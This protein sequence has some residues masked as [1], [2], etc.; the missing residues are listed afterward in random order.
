MQRQLTFE[1]LKDSDIELRILP[2]EKLFEIADADLLIALGREEDSRF[3]RK[4]P[5]IGPRGLGEYF[6]MWANTP[7]GGLIVVGQED[8]GELLGLLSLSTKQIN[9]IE[10]TPSDYCPDAVYRHKKILFKKE[11]GKDDFL[12]LFYVEY[13]SSR[14]V[15]TTNGKYFQ[16]EGQKKKE[17]RKELDIRHLR[18]EKNEVSAELEPVD[19]R[20]PKD[21]DKASIVAWAEQV[22]AKGGLT[23]EYQTP[24]NIL[25]INRLGTET[26]EGFVPNLACALLFATRPSDVAAGARIHFLRFDGKEQGT[27]AKWNATKDEFV[28]GTIPTQIA[29][30]GKLL[31]SQLRNFSKLGP[32]GKFYTA[33]EYPEDAWY[34]ALVNACVHR[35]YSNGLRKFRGDEFIM[36]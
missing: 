20:Y 17:I 5:G 31:N 1:D 16:R 33:S 23:P 7:Q 18:Q 11:D 28:D 14:L 26:P 27:G 36:V 12:F 21:F 34:E 4:S 30:C 22:V 29:E 35:T 15:S 10:E 25:A 32:G 24:E 6:S 19:L 13:H 2:P 8:K 9:R 3:E